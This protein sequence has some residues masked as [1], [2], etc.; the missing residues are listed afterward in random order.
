MALSHDVSLYHPLPGPRSIRLLRIYPGADTEPLSCSLKAFEDYR[1]APR[2]HGLSY[3]WGDVNDTVIVLC[4]NVSIRIT[5]SLYSALLRLRLRGQV[6]YI[7][8]SLP[9]CQRWS[10]FT[11]NAA[12]AS[13]ITKLLQR[14]RIFY[15]S[16]IETSN[17]DERPMRYASTKGM[18]QSA[19]SKSPS[20]HIF[21]DTPW[22][23]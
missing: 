17:I 8:V 3:C 5:R 14:I 19:I 18:F 10:Q 12:V 2:Y 7:W 1:N 22:E 11:D 9:S 13:I 15:D 20:W 16:I 6:S 21:S 4:N 23:F